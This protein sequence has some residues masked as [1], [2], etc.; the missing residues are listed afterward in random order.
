MPNKNQSLLKK[1]SILM[2][3]FLGIDFSFICQQSIWLFNDHIL[4]LGLSSF[5]LQIKHVVTSM[6]GNFVYCTLER[7]KYSSSH[8]V[9][10]E[11][12]K[13][14]TKDGETSKWNLSLL[15]ARINVSGAHS[16]KLFFTAERNKRKKENKKK[17][18]EA[19]M[20]KSR[21]RKRDGLS[22]F[23]GFSI[24]NGTNACK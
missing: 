6:N 9:L 19:R 20:A 21:N 16:L 18:L 10:N 24:T 14:K 7:I 4:L 11:W 23:S 1:L 5:L 17:V 13:K 12:K 8:S 22:I 15:Q 3:V 2:L